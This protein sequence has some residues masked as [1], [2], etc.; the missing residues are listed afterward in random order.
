MNMKKEEFFTPGEYILGDSAFSKSPVLVQ[1]FKKD[2]NTGYLDP[3]KEFFNSKLASLRI[4]SEHCIG[5]LKGRFQCLKKLNTSLKNE[6]QMGHVLGLIESAA[7]LH[8][9]I[10]AMHSADKEQEQDFGVMQ[11]LI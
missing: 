11:S 6:Q 7:I 4:K 1:S 10:L 2:A 9:I 8:N 5:M 3:K